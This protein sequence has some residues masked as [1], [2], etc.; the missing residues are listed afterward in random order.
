MHK[1]LINYLI[2][3]ALL[4]LTQ[5]MTLSPGYT[6]LDPW[7]NIIRRLFLSTI[8]RFCW[9]FCEKEGLAILLKR[10]AALHTVKETCMVKCNLSKIT[11]FRFKIPSKCC[12]STSFYLADNVM[13]LLLVSHKT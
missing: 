13:C 9:I 3:L 5:N 8:D 7:L 10:S 12:Y 2:I 4:M 1:V 11:S 6:S